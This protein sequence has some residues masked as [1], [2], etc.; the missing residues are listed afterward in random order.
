[1]KMTA[2][3]MVDSVGMFN[4]PEFYA[5]RPALRS[6]LSGNH[7][8]GIYNKIKSSIGTNAA[9]AFVTMVKNLNNLAPANF[10]NA[11]YAL[12]RRNWVYEPVEEIDLGVGPVDTE[13]IKEIFLAKIGEFPYPQ[14]EHTHPPYHSF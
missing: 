13:Y 10:L 7:L 14:R 9:E 12:E 1:M 6:D 4:R 8:Y 11:L 3:E 2:R 5:D